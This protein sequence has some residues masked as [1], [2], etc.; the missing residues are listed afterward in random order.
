MMAT[1]YL[2]V[3]CSFILVVLSYLMPHRHTAESEKLVW[4]S[5]LA[6][7]RSRGERGGLDYRLLAM[8]LLIA[9]IALYILF[10]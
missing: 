2:F 1:F 6:A 8:L 10:A 3:I 9:M 5:P 4:S 7:L